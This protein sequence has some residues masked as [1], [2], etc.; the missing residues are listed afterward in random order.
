[1]I[2]KLRVRLEITPTPTLGN[3]TLGMPRE[4]LPRM[5]QMQHVVTLQAKS[6][7]PPRH[8]GLLPLLG[9][10]APRHAHDLRAD[11]A[12]RQMPSAVGAAHTRVDARRQQRVAVRVGRRRRRRGMLV[13]Q[14]RLGVAVDAAQR[15]L[16]GGWLEGRYAVALGAFG[17][18]DLEFGAMVV[19]LVSLEVGAVGVAPGSA[20][21]VVDVPRVADRHDE[22][23]G[24]YVVEL[25][26]VAGEDVDHG[27]RY[28]GQD[29][30]LDV[31]GLDGA[32]DL[33]LEPVGEL[34]VREVQD[35]NEGAIS[36]GEGL[37]VCDG[38]P[39]S[40]G[41]KG[42]HGLEI[43]V[44][45]RSNVL[46]D[47]K[48]FL[49]QPLVTPAHELEGQGYEKE[50]RVGAAGPLQDLDGELGVAPEESSGCGHGISLCRIF[51]IDLGFRAVRVVVMYVAPAADLKA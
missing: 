26:D 33:I 31:A 27:V 49:C 46:V 40:G 12:S 2:A 51:G 35:C 15:D 43:G 3:R 4:P 39:V 24:L 13:R 14:G 22:D 34:V 36:Q 47:V 7:E 5:V 42:G 17:G 44:C 6:R 28:A 23:G 11:H 50:L 16:A 41:N 18:L 25:L 37:L 29:Y 10:V 45:P 19:H 8:L 48:L 1:M 21:D 32:D 20:A 30:A 9:T 38:G